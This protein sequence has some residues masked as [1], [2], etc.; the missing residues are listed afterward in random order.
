MKRF[1]VLFAAALISAATPAIADAQPRGQRGDQ[2]FEEPQRGD[3]SGRGRS[4]DRGQSQEREIPLP[5]LIRMV[6]RSTGGEYV[7]ANP[8]MMGGRKFYWMRLRFPGGRFQDYMVDATT[9]Q[10]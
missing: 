1:L 9:G 3:R 8:R 10:F 5:T 6:E 4:N 7:N 2:Q